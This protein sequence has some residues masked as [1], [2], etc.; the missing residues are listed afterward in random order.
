MSFTKEINYD[1]YVFGKLTILNWWFDGEFAET[2]CDC[3][4]ISY[5]R[6]GKIK[7]GARSSCA[8]GFCNTRI[9]NIVGQ[10]FGYLTVLEYADNKYCLCECCCGDIKKYRRDSLKNNNT[11]SCGCKTSYFLSVAGLKPKNVALKT[12]IYNTYKSNA[13]RRKLDFT[14]SKEEFINF[15]DKN[16]YYCGSLPASLARKNW[17]Y[18]EQKLLYNGVDRTNNAA[19]YNLE[20]C[21]T[22]CAICNM[23]KSDLDY[24]KFIE[25]IDNLVKFRISN[26][27]T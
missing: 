19:G 9:K 17:G 16:C 20:N 24:S 14:L 27:L 13:K 7:N 25:W 21:V 5:I 22:C 1:G 26:K 2:K 10:V 8:Q 11:R 6:R 12:N 15:L 18:T 4:H 3:G 23:A